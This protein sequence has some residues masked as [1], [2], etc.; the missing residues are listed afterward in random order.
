MS[1]AVETAAP[2][3]SCLTN[4]YPG[5]APRAASTQGKVPPLKTTWMAKSQTEP[6][7]PDNVL[8]KEQHIRGKGLTIRVFSFSLSAKDA[9]NR[10]EGNFWS[11]D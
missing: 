9:P 8:H 11:W 4:H 6:L 2:T 5:F 10:V 1:A 3:P 7:Q